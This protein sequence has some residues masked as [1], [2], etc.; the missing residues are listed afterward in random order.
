[1]ASSLSSNH[2]L[3]STL[4]KRQRSKNPLQAGFTLIELLVVIIIIGILAAIALPAYLNQADKAKANSAKSLV[5][6]AAKEC[7]AYLVDPVGPWNQT[8]GGGGNSIILTPDSESDQASDCDPAANPVGEWEAEVD[9]K[10][11]TYR[12]SISSDGTV[13]KSCTADFGCTTGTW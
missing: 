6:A 13:T 4:A 2:L 12:T 5:S 10:G 8:T 11:W 7:Q 9:G 1:M 3:I